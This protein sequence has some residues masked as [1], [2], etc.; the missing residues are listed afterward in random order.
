MNQPFSQS[1]VSWYNQ[2]WFRLTVG[3]FLA[4]VAPS[5]SVAFFIFSVVVADDTEN[6]A[7]FLRQ[8]TLRQQQEL[9]ISLGTVQI[10]LLEFVFNASNEILLSSSIRLFD[11]IES[12]Q[13]QETLYPLLAGL[14]RQAT[15]YN[16]RARVIDVQGNVIA[17]Y[18]SEDPRFIG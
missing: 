2:L 11:T 14:Q 5:L 3:F 7:R 15:E 18:W 17:G 13:L 9:D 8:T 12:D 1:S 6:A 10:T 16:G 4:V